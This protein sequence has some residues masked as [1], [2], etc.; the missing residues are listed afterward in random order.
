MG[1][2]MVGVTRILLLCVVVLMPPP[3]DFSGRRLP[4]AMRPKVST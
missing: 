3:T 2:L 4:R 1:T